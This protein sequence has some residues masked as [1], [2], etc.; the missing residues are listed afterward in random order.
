MMSA[1]V[2]S[3]GVHSGH[4]Q[5]AAGGRDAV[6][7]QGGDASLGKSAPGMHFEE[8][9]DVVWTQGHAP[10]REAL[11]GFEGGAEQVDDAFAME[12]M[13]LVFT[14][15]ELSQVIETESDDFIL[16]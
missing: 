13:G 9:G 7:R 2:Q 15:R 10:V 6:I 12:H 5:A 16:L 8:G 14:E 3:E 11:E 1:Q 4:V